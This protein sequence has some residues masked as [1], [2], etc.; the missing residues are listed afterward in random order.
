L[1]ENSIFYII[2]NSDVNIRLAFSVTDH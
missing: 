1:F 2:E